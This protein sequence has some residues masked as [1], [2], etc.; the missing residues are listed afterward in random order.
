MRQDQI[1]ITTA[2]TGLIAVCGTT[3]A[4]RSAF[5]HGATEGFFLG[6]AFSLGFGFGF[7]VC[8]G[9][10]LGFCFGFTLG[11]GLG[12]SLGFCFGFT[13]GFGLGFSLGFCFGLALGLSLGFCSRSRFFLSFLLFL[14]LAL[15]TVKTRQH[16]HGQAKPFIQLVIHQ[17]DSTARGTVLGG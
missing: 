8:L 7:S 16:N 12:F 6:L 11:F 17:V 14:L 13:L 9:L 4:A 15:T 3:G 2:A 10:G 5:A 1:T